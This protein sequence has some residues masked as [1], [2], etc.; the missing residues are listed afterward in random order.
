MP[1]QLSDL[2]SAGILT[3]VIAIPAN[4]MTLDNTLDYLAYGSAVE[5]VK[6][7]FELAA[8]SLTNLLIGVSCREHSPF[9]YLFQLERRFSTAK[10]RHLRR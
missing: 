8:L 1:R 5:K 9:Y 10:K 3:V 6:P 4:E 2:N 7:S